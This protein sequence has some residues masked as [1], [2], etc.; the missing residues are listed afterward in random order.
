MTGIFRNNW[1]EPVTKCNSE[2]KPLGQWNPRDTKETY[3]TDLGEACQNS[4]K[5]KKLTDQDIFKVLSKHTAREAYAVPS[6]PIL[7]P[8]LVFVLL[9]A[10]FSLSYHMCMSMILCMY[11]NYKEKA[12]ICLSETT[13]TC[14]V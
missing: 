8:P 11:I 12:C 13:F 6:P 7:P 9:T 10:S 5:S 1:K 2:E 3:F 14:Q 4:Y